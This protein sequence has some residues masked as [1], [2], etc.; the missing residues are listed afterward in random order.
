MKAKKAQRC[1]RS[2]ASATGETTVTFWL[3]K[4]LAQKAW[5][6]AA[7]EKISFDDYLIK[8]LLEDEDVL[9]RLSKEGEAKIIK[10]PR[11]DRH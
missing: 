9:C 4:S 2:K 10:F 11:S 5:N 8:L 7:Q 3:P 6:L 1:K